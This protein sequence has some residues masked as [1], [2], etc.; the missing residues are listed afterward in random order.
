LERRIRD[1]GQD[2][3]EEIARRLR[4]ARQEMESFALYDFIVVNDD[5]ERAGR[6]VHAIGLGTRC[7]SS[8]AR[9]VVERIL[10][11]FGG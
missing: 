8:R 2:S 4:Q 5:L 6:E 1:R 11:T 10:E 7:R 3:N 9:P